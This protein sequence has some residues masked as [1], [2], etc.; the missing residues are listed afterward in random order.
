MSDGSHHPDWFHGVA[1]QFLAEATGAAPRGTNLAE[2]SLCAALERAARE[3]SLQGGREVALP[4]V[5]T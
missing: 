5:L 1:A 2:A 4:G 3:S